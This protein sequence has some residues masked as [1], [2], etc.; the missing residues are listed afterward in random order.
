[1]SY[2][3]QLHSAYDAQVLRHTGLLELSSFAHKWNDKPRNIK[4]QQQKN[5]CLTIEP[6]GVV[7]LRPDWVVLAKCAKDGKVPPHKVS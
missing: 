6:A 5:Q 4:K 2:I 7:L 1:M 3:I